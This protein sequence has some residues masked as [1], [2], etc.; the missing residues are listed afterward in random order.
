MIKLFFKYFFG[1]LGIAVCGAVALD[2]FGLLVKYFVEIFG[3]VA[4]ST[5][6]LC[7][8][9]VLLLSVCAAMKAK[10]ENERRMKLENDKMFK[11]IK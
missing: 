5:E 9:C 3:Y 8:L 11:G 7:I 10:G 2:L 4:S 6:I 1:G